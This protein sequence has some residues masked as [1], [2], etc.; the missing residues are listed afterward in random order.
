MQKLKNI[1][2]GCVISGSVV[3][4]VFFGFEIYLRLFN[5]Q[6][7]S[8][9]QP[10][11]V[12]GTKHIPGLKIRQSNSCMKTIT[13]FNSEGMHDIEHA[14]Q[15]PEGVYRIA[16]IGDSYVEAMQYD[17]ENSFFKQLELN[18]KK[19]GKSVEVL[20]FGVG[21]FGTAQEYFLLRDYALKYSPDLVILS[22]YTANDVRNN[23]FELEKSPDMP[24][25]ILDEDGNIV[26]N[27][28]KISE[29]YLK[30]YNSRLRSLIFDNLHSVRF[31]YRNLSRSL[32]LRNLMAKI[33]L[34]TESE[35]NEDSTDSDVIYFANTPPEWQE[36]WK[37]TEALILK[38]RDESKSHGAEFV[39]FSLSNPEQVSPELFAKVEATH[40]GIEINRKKSEEKLTEFSMNND[41]NYFQ[42]LPF[43]D[44]LN[45]RGIVVHPQCHGHWSLEAHYLA[46]KLLSDYILDKKLI[47]Q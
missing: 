35:S 1:L 18:L 12:I 41:I 46:G 34:Q 3:L 24:Y 19:E 45:S 29:S 26:F 6:M 15:K 13:Q 38:M 30:Q 5:P 9:L 23:S 8:F 36:S 25:A 39:V 44:E 16:V 47:N 42:A 14:I 37:L 20:S 22:F 11:P 10:D 7:V 21:G 43:M 40:S 31:V 28:F 27:D 17:L 4:L 32:V 2:I 33:N